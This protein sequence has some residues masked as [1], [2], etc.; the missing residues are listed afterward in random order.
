MRETPTEPRTAHP[1]HE[2][3]WRDIAA[4][5]GITALSIVLSVHFNVNEA[6]YALTRRGERFQIDELPIG[7]LVNCGPGGSLRPA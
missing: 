7:M 5:I 6:L 4:V 2:L 3:P 1:A